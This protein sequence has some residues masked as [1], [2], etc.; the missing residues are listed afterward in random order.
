M[1]AREDYN[2]SVIS[3][4]GD[5]ISVCWVLLYGICLSL[6]AFLKYSVYLFICSAEQAVYNRPQPADKT[7]SKEGKDTVEAYQLAQRLQSMVRFWG[8]GRR[9]WGGEH[10]MCKF[11]NFLFSRQGISGNFFCLVCCFIRMPFNASVSLK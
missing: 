11:F 2:Q 5:V 4:P 9:R 3:P 8:W 6:H 1:V 10:L 7:R